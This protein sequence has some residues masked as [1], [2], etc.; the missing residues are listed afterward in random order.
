MARESANVEASKKGVLQSQVDMMLAQ[1][2][3]VAAEM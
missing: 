2:G 1:M 3:M